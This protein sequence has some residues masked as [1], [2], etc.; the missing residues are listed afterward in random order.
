MMFECGSPDFAPCLPVDWPSIDIR[1]RFHE[2]DYLITVVQGDVGHLM[3]DGIE[4]G[5]KAI[6]LIND[7]QEHRVL[8]KVAFS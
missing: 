6:Q 2:T 5:S 4:Q 1:Y 3:L 7:L 8:V